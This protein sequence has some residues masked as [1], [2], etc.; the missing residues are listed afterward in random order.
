MQLPGEATLPGDTDD[1]EDWAADV[2]AD[3]LDRGLD[4]TL[5]PRRVRAIDARLAD[6][7]WSWTP[8]PVAVLD[9]GSPLHEAPTRRDYA[10]SA[11][12]A[13]LVGPQAIPGADAGAMARMMVPAGAASPFA[14]MI[15][16]G[17]EASDA[18][19]RIVDE[20]GAIVFMPSGD[21]RSYLAKLLDGAAVHELRRGWTTAGEVRAWALDL[22]AATERELDER[23]AGPATVE[24]VSG[25]HLALPRM[26]LLSVLRGVR[27]TPTDQAFKVAEL[28]MLRDMINQLRVLMPDGEYGLLKTV[29]PACLHAFLGIV[30][31][32]SS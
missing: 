10:T 18:D 11:V 19:P 4:F 1:P 3:A 27:W 32:R 22:C 29:M 16:R 2:A 5:V 17:G 20:T 25:V 6:A 30:D 12:S 21:M 24:W 28:L 14:S 8:E 9:D 31:D 23:V 15:E 7:G 26:T 13:M